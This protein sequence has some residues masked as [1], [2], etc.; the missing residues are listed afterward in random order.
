[1]GDVTW[2]SGEITEVRHDEKLGPLIEVSV[3]GTNQRGSENIR[4]TATILLP[5]RVH[6]PVKLP[7]APPPTQH[8]AA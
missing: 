3:S 6:G 2:L 5:S 4:A 8:R 7:Q 1:M